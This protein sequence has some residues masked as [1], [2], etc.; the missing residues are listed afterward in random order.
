[1]PVTAYLVWLKKD[2][3]A[4]IPLNPRPIIGG[5]LVLLA[6]SFLLTGRVGGVPQIECVSLMILLPGLILF[7]LGRQHLKALLLPYLYLQFMVPWF[8]DFMDRIYKPFQLISAELGTMV[9]KL[10]GYPV[11]HNE[12][13]IELPNISLVVAEE[14]SGIKFLI[15]ILA[16]AVPLAYLTQ[17]RWRRWGIIMVSAFLI[18]LVTNGARVA[19]AGIMGNTYG[20]ELLHGPGHI[21]RGWFVAQVGVIFLF[22]VNWGVGRLHTD[23]DERL[24]ERGRKKWQ[25]NTESSGRAAEMRKT[26]VALGFMAAFA[27]YMYGFAMPQPIALKEDIVAFPF[28]VGNWNGS[29]SAW[30][31]GE[32]YF[33]GIEHELKRTYTTETGRQVYFYMGYYPVQNQDERLI[34]FRS[35][36]LHQSAKEVSFNLAP[37]RPKFVNHTVMDIEGIQFE[38]FFWYRLPSGDYTDRYETKLKTMTDGLLRR[39]NHGAVILLAIPATD[40]DIHD[41]NSIPA[42]LLEFIGDIAPLLPDFLPFDS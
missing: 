11:Y 4:S 37:S 15:S 40:K 31:V 30:F 16:I 5:L 22:I 27:V 13:Y 6:A 32:K 7:L 14:C 25:S 18:T 42:D 29:E 26:F 21:F 28:K 9:L 36:P 17:K 12:I 8:D 23:R 35:R 33:P 1:L 20:A 41:N 34:S 38:A 3:L 19:F 39:R 10:V 24:F 2:Q